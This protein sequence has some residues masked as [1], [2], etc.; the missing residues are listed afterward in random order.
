M[1]YIV[2]ISKDAYKQNNT[3]YLRKGNTM[4]KSFV[5]AAVAATIAASSAMASGT[6]PI[7]VTGTNTV[8]WTGSISAGQLDDVCNFISNTS[9][10]M[11]FTGTTW[12]TDVVAS[13]E[14]KQRNA[15]KILVQPDHYV[16]EID[17]SGAILANG[18][19][20]AVNVDYAATGSGTASSQAKAYIQDATT[21]Q[22]VGNVETVLDPAI[23]LVTLTSTAGSNTGLSGTISNDAGQLVDDNKAK[24]EL[25]GTAT[26]NG[27]GSVNEIAIP[28]GHLKLD[29]G[30]TAEL[31]DSS[32]VALLKN[33]SRYAITHTVTC[34]K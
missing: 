11:G 18:V 1:S 15:Y 2:Y 3:Y 10:S 34:L 25:T 21:P 33:G 14:L 13:V 16:R 12:T 26:I 9:G 28:F 7:T 19:A 30:G 23:H 17:A 5:F 29:I 22:Q 32:D 24:L 6:T 27:D 20:H 8:D 4:K 31:I